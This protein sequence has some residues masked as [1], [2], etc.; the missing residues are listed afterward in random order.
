[1]ARIIG[2]S[3]LDRIK[4]VVRKKNVFP[5]NTKVESDDNLFDK[6]GLDSAGMIS[7]VVALEEE[8]DLEFDDAALELRNFET[9]HKI[10]ILIEE[11][12]LCSSGNQG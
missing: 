3:I 12:L 7:L 8:F 6:H 10:G 1:M 5:S 11:T 4:H 2:E 9:I